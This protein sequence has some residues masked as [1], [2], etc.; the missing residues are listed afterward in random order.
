[1]NACSNGTPYN[2]DISWEHEEGFL[3]LINY[4]LHHRKGIPHDP[5]AV[6]IAQSGPHMISESSSASSQHKI[7]MIFGLVAGFRE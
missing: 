5:C 6:A 4:C 1:M 7:K 3:E 2:Y